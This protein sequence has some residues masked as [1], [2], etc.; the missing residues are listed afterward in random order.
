MA[1]PMAIAPAF[2][3]FQSADNQ[4]RAP[5]SS[6]G[7]IQSPPIR[8]DLARGESTDE[9][10]T[11]RAATSPLFYIPMTSAVRYL[12]F[13]NVVPH[14]HRDMV[15]ENLNRNTHHLTLPMTT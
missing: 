11:K 7:E 3:I 10:P 9:N 2:L 8:R 5:T 15:L 6:P 13:H 14:V 1:H 12:K 4:V